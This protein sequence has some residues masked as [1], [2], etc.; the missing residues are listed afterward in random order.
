MREQIRKLVR[1]ETA[2]KGQELFVVAGLVMVIVA[3]I[4]LLGFADFS[5]DW[6]W[7]IAGIGLILEGMIMVVKQKKF[8]N[9]LSSDKNICMDCHFLFAVKCM[10]CPSTGMIKNW[11]SLGA[12][13]QVTA[14]SLLGR[15]YLGYYIKDFAWSLVESGQV[16]IVATDAHDTQER[17]AMMT[18]AYEAISTRLGP[19]TAEMLCIENPRRVIEAKKPLKLESCG[20]IY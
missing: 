2:Y 13:L 19:E 16:S 8:N 18:A 17:K 15:G 3:L 7:F 9:P 1:F 12:V 11:L 6:F 10:G 20:V 5:S 14:A 4:K